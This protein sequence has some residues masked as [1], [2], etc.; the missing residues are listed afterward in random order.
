MAAVYFI[1]GVAV[2]DRIDWR[3]EVPRGPI[4]RRV[5]GFP[6]DSSRYVT[7]GLTRPVIIR[8]TGY[9]VASDMDALH[10]DVDAAAALQNDLNTHS[11]RM[12]NRTWTNCDLKELEVLG[13][14]DSLGSG[15]AQRVRYVWEKLV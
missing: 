11:V 7:K 8:V 1:D 4:P 3:H 6:G 14:P 2:N 9:L 12:H 13:N 15:V 5:E 10:D